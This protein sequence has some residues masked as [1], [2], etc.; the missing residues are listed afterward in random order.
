MYLLWN[1]AVILLGGWQS[2]WNET[3]SNITL[4]NQLY[5]VFHYQIGMSD[6]SGN[7]VSSSYRL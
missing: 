2:V 4:W 3:E 5:S 6:G 1:F 7:N